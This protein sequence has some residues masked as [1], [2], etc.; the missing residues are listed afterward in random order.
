MSSHALDTADPVIKLED[1]VDHNG[2]ARYEA[3][4]SGVVN[5]DATIAPWLD[6]PV[7]SYSEGFFSV[8]DLY[9]FIADAPSE[10]SF[11]REALGDTIVRIFAEDI[12]HF[13]YFAAGQLSQSP[14]R[15]KATRSV[16]EYLSYFRFQATFNR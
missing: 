9:F 7:G 10:I 2:R 15:F 8:V 1:A 5:E 12:A 16:A 11:T 4:T 13:F 3:D 14:A 6:V